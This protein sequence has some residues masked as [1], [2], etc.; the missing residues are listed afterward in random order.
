V[1]P[2]FLIEAPTLYDAG[3]QQGRLASDRIRGWLSSREMTDLVNYT[4]ADG[5]GRAALTQLVRDNTAVFPEL[6]DE[7]RGVAAGA[8]VPMQTVWVATL[9]TE[10]EALQPQGQWR[11][12][13][14]SD[15]FARGRPGSGL[16]HGHNEDWPGPV[17]DYFYFAAYRPAPGTTAVPRC[18][19]LVYPG[20]LVAYAPAW[21][22]HGLY[23]TVNTL[24]PTAVSGR[25]LGSAFVQRRALCGG[26]ESAVRSAS[27]RRR[28]LWIA[29]AD[30]RS[31]E[32]VV[33]SLGIG[34]WASGASV[35]LV[36][37]NAKRAVNVEVHG[38][39]LSVYEVGLGV[40]PNP[41]GRSALSPPAPAAKS[42]SLPANYSHFNKYKHL[43]PH[44]TLDPAR[45]ST[46]HRQARVD[47]LPAPR[48]AA[49]VRT[50]LSDTADRE[51]PVFRRMTLA[52]LVLQ[53]DEKELSVWCCGHAPREGGA[54]A[55]RWN[56]SSFFD[57]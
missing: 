28:A 13:H 44:G 17:H 29:G 30:I 37:L 35:N 53:V 24:F 4:M 9:M 51:Y 20:G 5:I 50:R 21:N 54:A 36:D 40:L 18:A 55:Y 15:I 48:T 6:V 11:D 47:A 12:G 31:L 38:A 46:A 1:P 23:Q 43:H 8:G 19:G 27:S 25:G 14:C 41:T 45:P 57:W 42:S 52:S 32:G 49:D 39:D 16:V 3:F 10:L 34:A 56:L 33:A 22:G 26:G 7:L 2:L